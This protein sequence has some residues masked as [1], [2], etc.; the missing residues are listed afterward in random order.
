V[1]YVPCRPPENKPLPPQKPVDV[2][3]VG[4][5]PPA[6]RVVNA[7]LQKRAGIQGT[8]W[9]NYHLVAAQWVKKPDPGDPDKDPTLRPE[10]RVTNTTL[11]TYKQRSSCVAC[12]AAANA[13]LKFVFFPTVRAHPQATGP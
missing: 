6:A 2:K 11:E 5:I 12:H 7:E 8:H 4:E 9:R 10:T 1:D 13:D 3:R